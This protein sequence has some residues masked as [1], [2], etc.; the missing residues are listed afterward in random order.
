[1]VL[2]ILKQIKNFDQNILVSSISTDGVDGN[3]NY[4]GAIG[5]NDLPSLQKI[6]SYLKNNNSSAFFK[7]Y[8]GL[9]ETGPTNTNLMDIGLI[10]K[11]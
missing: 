10:I 1:M 5:K 11:Y 2:Q 6:S 3:T 4:C 9:I 8:G 7:K